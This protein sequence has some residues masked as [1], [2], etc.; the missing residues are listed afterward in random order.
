MS[1]KETFLTICLSFV[2]LHSFAQYEM[3]PLWDGNVPNSVISDEV[4]MIRRG[5]VLYVSLVQTPTLEVHLPTKRHATGRS[6]IICPGGG[7]V[8]LVYDWEGTDIAKWFNSKGIA[9][10]VLKSRLPNSKSIKVSYEA[11]LQDAQRAMR[12]VRSQADKWGIDP[13]KI[14]IMGFSAGGHLASTLGTQFSKPNNFKESAIDTVSA[15]PDFM[16][17]IYP[18]IT[19]KS[20]YT[21]GGSRNSLLGNNPSNDL[22]NQY[23][24]ELQVTENTP[25][26]F[27]VHSEDDGAVP[28]EN[29][30]QLYKALKDKG[31]KTEMHLYP[32]GGHGYSLALGKGHLETW[33]DRLYD[34]L[35]SL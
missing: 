4:E 22:V 14:G 6:V 20:D 33:T 17:L 21:H 10:F 27:L 23:S 16:V 30:L 12:I 9:A 26:T 32:Y 28:V 19:M 29:S 31:I 25:P 8:N 5:D 34:W 2:M 35:K 3:I 24:N 15:R 13:N 7:Y 18:V 11:P 1:L